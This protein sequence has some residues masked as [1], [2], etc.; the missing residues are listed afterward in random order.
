M[1]NINI[2]KNCILKISDITINTNTRQAKF[3]GKSIGLTGME[4][5]LLYYL[6][7]NK[8]VGI[9]RSELL[10]NIWGYRSEI[11]SR[12]P[13]DMLKRIRK[14]LTCVGSALKIKTMRG[15][16]FMIQQLD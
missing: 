12:A 14:K 6:V 11:E 9:S 7:E 1:F 10:K 16:G 13:D 5:S 15:F 3:N 2:E 4:F 8:N